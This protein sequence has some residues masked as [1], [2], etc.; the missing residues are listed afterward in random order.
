M[1]FEEALEHVLKWESGFSNHPQ[2]PGGATNLG[3]TQR[4]LSEWRR[5]PVS[6]EELRVLSGAD[7][8]PLY[9]QRYWDACRCGELPYG[10]DLVVFDSAVNQGPDRAK[11]LLQR[12]LGVREDGALGP[13]TMSVAQERDRVSL[14]DEMTARRAVH[15][16]GLR[17]IF[18]LGWFRRLSSIHRH[19]LE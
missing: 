4:T 2:D 16:A 5:R 13:V 18:H 7:V 1:Q 8:A 9:R 12:A 3:I 6:L 14:I 10:L 17:R 19:A 11:R 15:Y